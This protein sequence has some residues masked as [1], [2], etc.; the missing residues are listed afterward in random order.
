MWNNC[1][2]KTVQKSI[3]TIEGIY[4]NPIKTIIYCCKTPFTCSKYIRAN[5]TM[6]YFDDPAGGATAPTGGDDATPTPAEGGDSTPAEGGDSTP[7][8][9]DAP[10]V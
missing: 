1:L 7:A 6:T 2:T 10:S 3:I 5:I 9:G 4:Y 8:G